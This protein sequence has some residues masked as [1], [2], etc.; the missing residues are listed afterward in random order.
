MKIF[1]QKDKDFPPGIQVEIASMQFRGKSLKNQQKT[2]DRGTRFWLYERFKM[3]WE[4]AGRRV[5][6]L[7]SAARQR[8]GV[9]SF[10]SASLLYSPER[11]VAALAE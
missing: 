8:R 1:L 2:V 5:R 9:G 6:M 3:V 7:A 4:R 11:G 10:H